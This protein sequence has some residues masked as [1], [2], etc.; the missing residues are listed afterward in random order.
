MCEVNP[1]SFKPLN[2]FLSFG[3][4][5][6]GLETEEMRKYRHD[7]ERAHNECVDM[8]KRAIHALDDSIETIKGKRHHGGT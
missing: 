5:I 6:L 8:M 7:Q 2:L 4:R 1:T 3:A